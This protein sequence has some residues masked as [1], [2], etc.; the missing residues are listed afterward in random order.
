MTEKLKIKKKLYIFV[1]YL[2]SFLGS[3]TKTEMDGL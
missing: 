1:I 3:E 2:L